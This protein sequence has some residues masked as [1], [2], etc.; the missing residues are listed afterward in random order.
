MASGYISF[1]KNM[2]GP[3]L[4]HVPTVDESSKQILRKNK[5]RIC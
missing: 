4:P 3:T 5:H 2:H 1:E